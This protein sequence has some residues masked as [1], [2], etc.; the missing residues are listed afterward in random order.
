ME[1][2]GERAV[3]GVTSGL[4]ALGEIVTWRAKHFGIWQHLTSQITLFDP[5]YHFRDSQVRGAF[6][7]FDHDH[8]CIPVANGT[9]LL[10]LFD[11]TSPLGIFGKV[12]DMQILKRYMTKLLWQRNQVIK[13]I[14][15]SNEW[16]RFVG[17]ITSPSAPQATGS[18]YQYKE[19]T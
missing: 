15:E 3:A 7:R 2:H 16:H 12:V 19:T 10:D 13:Q 4:I 17:E 14:A 8:I 11:Y 18:G 9:R 6:Q 5:P 1:H